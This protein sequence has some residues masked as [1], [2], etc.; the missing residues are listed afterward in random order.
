MGGITRE[1]QDRH[2][3]SSYQRAAS[4]WQRGAMDSEVS[5]VRVPQQ[6]TLD[7]HGGRSRAVVVATDEE[8]SRLRMDDVASLP[9][10]FEEEGTITAG[11]A[12]SLNDG[13]AALVLIS[14]AKARELGVDADA[15]VLSFADSGM[16]AARFALAPSGAVRRA[17]KAAGLNGVD[18]HEIHETFAALVLANA[19]QMELDLSRI[20][21]NG[22]A[23]APG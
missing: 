10:V 7:S 18:F 6:P 5:P 12:A 14:A 13:A 1:D 21:V 11:S 4:A 20:N 3:I 8:Y 23:V 2:T 9:P 17:L 16:E 22:G 15:R 19:H